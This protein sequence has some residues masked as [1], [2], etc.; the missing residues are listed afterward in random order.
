MSA[1][2][3]VIMSSVGVITVLG[4]VRAFLFFLFPHHF[5]GVEFVGPLSF[6]NRPIRGAD[7]SNRTTRTVFLFVRWFLILLFAIFLAAVI[8]RIYIWE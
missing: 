8:M 2:D 4:L 1:L 5:R 3:I 7:I 6:P